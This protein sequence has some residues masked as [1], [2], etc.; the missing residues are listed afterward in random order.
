MMFF[1][2][3]CGST[4]GMAEE[5]LGFYMILIPL[6]LS[7]GYD[8][9]TGLMIVLFGAG[10]GVLTSTVNPFVIAVAVDAAKVE[11]LSSS[12]GMAWRWISWVIIT[13]AAIT[14]VT[15]Y[16]VKVKKIH[17]NHTLSQHL[18]VIKLSS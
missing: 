4:Y 18:K 7:M 1:F 6:V 15:L 5:T 14:M 17:K 9:F 10:A 11:G 8:K 16:A 12:N 2:S 13:G 3:F